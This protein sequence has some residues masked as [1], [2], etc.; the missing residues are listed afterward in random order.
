M[1][2]I[3]NIGLIYEYI[4]NAGPMGINGKPIFMSCRFLTK[5]DT[6]KMFE[7]FDKYKEIRELADK[8]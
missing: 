5:E 8:F 3:N 4:S 1:K 2:Y 7:Y 6:T